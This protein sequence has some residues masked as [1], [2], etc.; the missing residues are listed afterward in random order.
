VTQSAPALATWLS[1]L[2]ILSPI[3]AGKL[4]VF[5]L[6]HPLSSSL[7]YLTL[8][9]ALKT[10]VFD[11][12]EV[13]EGGTV[14]TLKVS[15]RTG[16]LVFLMAGEELVGAKQNRVLNVSIMVPASSD[17]PVPVSCVEAGRWRYTSDKFS[18]AG[19]SSHTRLRRVMSL[20]A[21]HFYR[22]SGRPLSDQSEVWE[23]VD[24]K[25]QGMK[26]SSPSQALHQVYEDHGRVLKD[27]Y[28][29]ASAPEGSHGAVFCV[30]GGVAGIDVF[31][32]PSTLAKLWPKV[33]RSYAIDALEAP[34]GMPEVTLDGVKAWLGKIL[35]AKIERYDSPGL[36][37]D[38]RFDSGDLGGGSLVVEGQ[39]V[40]AEVFPEI[41]EKP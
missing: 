13:S 29:S 21:K 23:E 35:E 34:D 1:N 24:S 15:N 7:A 22:S 2:E 9:E 25:L 18:S 12:T 39:P 41:H 19:T 3:R 4:Q 32:N 38:L 11:I 30:G 14:P 31:D 28:E 6:R 33:L 20:K 36:G 27:L 8:D 37:E 17:L 10:G 40:H 5:G 16:M 26:S